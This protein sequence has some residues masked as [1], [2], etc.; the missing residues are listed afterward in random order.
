MIF[1][2]LHGTAEAWIVPVD[3]EAIIAIQKLFVVAVSGDP[4][5]L[6]D[7]FIIWLDVLNEAVSFVCVALA[8]CPL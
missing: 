1:L 2:I 8:T 5:L 3:L 7:V 4:E 6:Y